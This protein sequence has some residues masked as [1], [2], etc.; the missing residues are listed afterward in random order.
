MD[1]FQEIDQLTASEI[2][3][4]VDA[5]L[6]KYQALFPDWEITTFSIFKKDDRSAQID[7]TIQLLEKLKTSR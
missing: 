3:A 1:I 2:N 7:R 4:V 6:A 5:V